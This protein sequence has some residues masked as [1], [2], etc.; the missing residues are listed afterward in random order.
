MT[1]PTIVPGDKYMHFKGNKYVIVCIAQN[2]EGQEDDIVVYQAI[3]TGTI[4]GKSLAVFCSPV[5][6]VL[7]PACLQTLQ[8]EKIYNA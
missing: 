4:Y 6:K 7:Y 8:F 5:D 3:N 2:Q 1:L